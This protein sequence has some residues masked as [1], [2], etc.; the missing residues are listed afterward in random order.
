VIW[1]TV[2]G[3]PARYIFDLKGGLLLI[4]DRLWVRHLSRILTLDAFLPLSFYND[5]PRVCG[6]T[7]D[8]L[9]QSCKATARSEW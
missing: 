5:P 2:F 8:P 1:V 9:R 7:L 3:E 4:S 6:D